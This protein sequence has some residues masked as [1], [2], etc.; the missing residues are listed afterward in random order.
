VGTIE[1]FFD[2]PDGLNVGK[3][4]G[5]LDGNVDGPEGIIV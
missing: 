2:G 5:I 3:N 4:D 1:G